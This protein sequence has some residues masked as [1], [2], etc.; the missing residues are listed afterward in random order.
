MVTT[1]LGK[2]KKSVGL[3]LLIVLLVPAL[4]TA[5]S[6]AAGAFS[7]I[8]Q[9]D[10][11]SASFENGGARFQIT[12]AGITAFSAGGDVLMLGFATNKK[13][14]SIEDASVYRLNDTCY[15]LEYCKG[16]FR[17]YVRPLKDLP[18]AKLLFEG[19]GPDKSLQKLYVT[20]MA[21]SL[22]DS[23]ST[24]DKVK[25]GKLTF[26]WSDE[27][28]HSASWDKSA[29]V[30]AFD[31]SGQ[32]MIDPLLGEE[33]GSYQTPHVDY[34]R[35][36]EE[37]GETVSK[38]GLG[39]LAGNLS[40]GFEYNLVDEL[41]SEGGGTAYATTETYLEVRAYADG[42]YL[43]NSQRKHGTVTKYYD[44]ATVSLHFDYYLYGN[45]KPSFG[46]GGD[47]YIM[48]Y[49]S[50]GAVVWSDSVYTDG[51][52]LLLEKTGTVD[53][54]NIPLW[55]IE[56]YGKAWNVDS[57][58]INGKARIDNLALLNA[59]ATDTVNYVSYSTT[60]ATY[61]STAINTG[62]AAW[63]IPKGTSVTNASSTYTVSGANYSSAYYK[64]QS[65]NTTHYI[66]AVPGFFNATWTQ[67]TGEWTAPNAVYS[68]DM[69]YSATYA[70]P[71]V[72]M[73]CYAV[74][75]DPYGD[76]IEGQPCT[77]L[78]L[79][80]NG[81]MITSDTEN[82]NSTG[83]IEIALTTPS[84]EGVYVYQANTSGLY[85]G[86]FNTT[87]KVS[88]LDLYCFIDGERVNNGSV[89]VYGT[90][91]HSLDA[92]ETNGFIIFNGTPITIT[93]GSFS[94]TIA[95]NDVGSHTLVI[96]GNDSGMVNTLTAGSNSS[97]TVIA[98]HAH[99]VPAFSS[100]GTF[101]PSIHS[102]YDGT[103]INASSESISGG[104]RY[105]GLNYSLANFT[106]L[107][108]GQ[109]YG[110]HSYY[111]TA[112][113]NASIIV[114]ESLPSTN[115]IRFNVTGPCNASVWLGGI[116]QPEQVALDGV[117]TTPTWDASTATLT[118]EVTSTEVE[119]TLSSES[120]APSGQ[121]AT[122]GPTI[123]PVQIPGQSSS[124]AGSATAGAVPPQTQAAVTF[125]MVTVAL[126]L[127]L[128]F[129]RRGRRGGGKVP[130]GVRVSVPKGIRGRS[131]S[132][133]AA[134]AIV[135]AAAFV[136]VTAAVGIS[137]GRLA[138]LSMTAPSTL[139]ALSTAPAPQLAAAL[140]TAAVIIGVFAVVLVHRVTFR[141]SSHGKSK[142]KNRR[143]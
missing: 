112:S 128:A 78:F 71:S 66:L 111:I 97:A 139:P 72:S 132:P 60:N 24:G 89:T 84:S 22:D 99:L 23:G 123:W 85:A 67:S 113:N 131:V 26:D 25:S 8:G 65:F 103:T 116:G 98:D 32:F 4:I 10:L 70:S 19:N 135:A 142:S 54:A 44:N 40:G 75:M 137:S 88:N 45:S 107:V 81:T 59:T 7:P 55:K 53:L 80:D 64:L 58:G 130:A 125:M 41:G 17:V 50:S 92:S 29:Q 100:D 133:L 13:A 82:S 34:F 122:G 31:V 129:W 5:S 120:E 74:L 46:W 3:A 39:N 36:F 68:I 51:S 127:G 143:K 14:F 119:L 96:T 43:T 76:P 38:T 90:A 62:T 115:T 109:L 114:T 52:D 101:S 20:I 30:L 124:P 110:A 15:V 28:K 126:V 77:S 47:A 6:Y 117:V 2:G 83:W 35:D 56:L 18:L 140:A 49:N 93:G 87:L 1:G 141:R 12:P 69:Q 73:L 57:G 91:T 33:E 94:G 95:L 42:D 108:E 138:G 106:W 102:E 61:S 63:I 21:S 105:Y 11:R 121:P 134:V 16:A 118:V 79:F 136:I 86:V 27:K 104:Y 9:Q 37:G 48:V